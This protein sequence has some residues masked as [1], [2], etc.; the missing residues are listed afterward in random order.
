MPR[1]KVIGTCTVCHEIKSL[2]DVKHSICG[3][4]AGK[5]GGSTPKK[6]RVHYF[7]EVCKQP[8]K[9]DQDRCS[10]G[11]LQDWHKLTPLVM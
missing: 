3:G 11:A 4:C 6:A 1:A 9:K 10:C 5:R 7:C 8:V 2:F